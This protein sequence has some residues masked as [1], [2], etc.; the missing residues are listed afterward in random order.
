MKIQLRIGIFLALHILCFSMIELRDTSLFGPMTFVIVYAVFN[1]I[2]AAGIFLH[3]FFRDRFAWLSSKKPFLAAFCLIY[4]LSGVMSL[5]SNNAAVYMV[6]MCL[7]ALLSGIIGGAA[8]FSI[9]ADI[10]KWQRGRVIGAGLL[11]GT[12]IHYFVELLRSLSGVYFIF[13]FSAVFFIA[14][15]GIYLLLSGNSRGNLSV[16]KGNGEKAVIYGNFKVLFLILVASTIAI[17]YLSSVYEGIMTAVSTG[18]LGSYELFLLRNTKLLYCVSAVT[19]G[20]IADLKG[21]QYI[22]VITIAV[23]T[24]L[25][26]DVFLLNYPVIK[27]IN[28]IVLFAGAGFP[29]MF[30]TLNFIDIAGQTKKPAIWTGGGR[31]IKHSVTALGSVAGTMLWNNSD[32]GYIIVILQY[33]I[34][35]IAL[36]F[37]LFQHYRFVTENVRSVGLSEITGIEKQASRLQSPVRLKE[38]CTNDIMQEIAKVYGLTEREGQILRFIFAGAQ[39]KDIAKELYITERT[40]KFHISNILKKT[41]CR[42]QRELVSRFV[43]LSGSEHINMALR[44]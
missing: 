31:M 20:L 24:F 14:S 1:L 6:S 25:I 7:S 19:A 3:G 4:W 39:I 9:Y 42:N 12:L 27:F 5:I 16:E 32:S 34:L 13:I 40:V 26:F 37:L 23:M 18:E 43:N 38:T 8:Y 15:A 36:I 11:F 2:F 22:S 35:L 41:A 33:L 30:V 28:W 17:C 21:R 44:G 29:A 10:L